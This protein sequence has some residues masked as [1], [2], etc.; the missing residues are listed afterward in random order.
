MHRDCAIDRW[1]VDCLLGEPHTRAKALVLSR[2][3]EKELGSAHAAALVFAASF[4]VGA[5][6]NAVRELL[7]NWPPGIEAVMDNYE[8]NGVWT[9]DGMIAIDETNENDDGQE[10]SIAFCLAM[11]C[12]AGEIVRT[13]V[14]VRVDTLG[15]STIAA[16]NHIVESTEQ[17]LPEEVYSTVSGYTP[18]EPGT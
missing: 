8:K 15:D 7:D 14:H 12:G 9:P 5:K 18:K 3:F 17:R 2:H 11:M 13:D 1:C 16:V 10:A 4:M 6:R